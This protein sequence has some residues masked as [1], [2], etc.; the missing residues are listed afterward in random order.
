MSMEEKEDTLLSIDGDLICHT[1][2]GKPIKPK[3]LWQKQYAD[4]IRNNM[5]VFF[6]FLSG[7]GKTYLAMPMA[8]TAF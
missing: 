5:I 7:T 3:T 6:F 2:S 1:I 8:L 4:A